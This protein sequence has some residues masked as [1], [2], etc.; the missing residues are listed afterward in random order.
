[1]QLDDSTQ[2]A[3]GEDGTEAMATAFKPKALLPFLKKVP[4]KRVVH[5]PNITT[6]LWQQ[7]PLPDGALGNLSAGLPSALPAHSH[8]LQRV[9]YLNALPAVGCAASHLLLLAPPPT[10]MALL[11]LLR[12]PQA[13]SGACLENHFALVCAAT[14]PAVVADSV[15]LHI[16]PAGLQ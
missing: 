4:T 3:D 1:M 9:P 13:L 16:L 6:G 8:L 14:Q 15:H 7:C 12:L 11:L 2:V 10:T 5:L